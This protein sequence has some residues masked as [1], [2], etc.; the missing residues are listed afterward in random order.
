MYGDVHFRGLAMRKIAA[1]FLALMLASSMLLYAAPSAF[2]DELP[3][4]DVSTQIETSFFSIADVDLASFGNSEQ[5]A[6]ADE[7]YCQQVLAIDDL[8]EFDVQLPGVEPDELPI[9]SLAL[10]TDLLP[11]DKIIVLDELDQALEEFF[12]LVHHTSGSSVICTDSTTLTEDNLMAHFREGP[13][14]QQL[15][16][17]VNTINVLLEQR[18][19]PSGPAISY[20]PVSVKGNLPRGF[21][22]SDNTLTLID[23]DL[24]PTIKDSGD[25]HKS[26]A[27]SYSITFFLS[28]GSS[29]LDDWF[30][31]NSFAALTAETI[32]IKLSLTQPPSDGTDPDS[33][34]D[35]DITEPDPDDGDD[36]TKPDPDD[37][38]MVI[39][40][41]SIAQAIPNPS[42]VMIPDQGSTIPD[43]V[44]ALVVV[45]FDPNPDPDPDPDPAEEQPAAV[46]HVSPAVTPSIEEPI[47]PMASRMIDDQG[48]L[49]VTNAS[50]AV[51]SL[52]LALASL[53]SLRQSRFNPR[54]LTNTA[55]QLGQTGLAMG[56]ISVGLGAISATLLVL[57]QYL[58]ITFH[59]LSI[60]W[61]PILI[62]IA[63][64]Q[65]ACTLGLLINTRLAEKRLDKTRLNIRY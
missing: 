17:L 33:D 19:L 64:V 30:P 24:L 6:L 36:V 32:I 29:Y 44:L 25:D 54:R 50:L 1:G 62:V 16:D 8:G 21:S 13:D 14:Y 35:G 28:T 49:I 57:S 58:D 5:S 51:L 26:P 43:I 23:L 37:N 45:S 60:A 12:N 22:F 59:N 4:E 42:F 47:I 7:T 48:N 10:K 39:G 53:V 38:H 15:V 41:G 56:I 20:L 18:G 3:S 34:P 31:G 2:A 11:L 27:H 65:V 40:S 55:V 61:T 52:I 9:D 46:H 63:I